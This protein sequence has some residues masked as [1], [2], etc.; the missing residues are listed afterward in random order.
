VLLKSKLR[1]SK[2]QAIVGGQE[3]KIEQAKAGGKKRAK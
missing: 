2:N 1:K 3:L